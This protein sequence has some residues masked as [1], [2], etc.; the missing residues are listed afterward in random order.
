[1]DLTLEFS[2]ELNMARNCVVSVILMRLAF[3]FLF[4]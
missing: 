4:S 1:M 3:V 2:I